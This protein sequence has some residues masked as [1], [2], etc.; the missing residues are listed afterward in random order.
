MKKFIINLGEVTEQRA[1]ETAYQFCDGWHIVE[2]KRYGFLHDVGYEIIA[3]PVE[4]DEEPT[5]RK[6]LKN[7]ILTAR[8]D[9]AKTWEAANNDYAYSF[10]KIV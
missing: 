8:R 2:L 6:E 4:N 9:I 7:L 1:V 10:K 5:S 3:R